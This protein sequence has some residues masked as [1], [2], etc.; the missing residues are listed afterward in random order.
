VNRA[1][2]DRAIN[3]LHV[4]L[5]WRSLSGRRTAI[6]TVASRLIGAKKS[7]A[8][9]EPADTELLATAAFVQKTYDKLKDKT[10]GKVF[11]S[12]SERPRRGRS[13]DP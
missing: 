6:A 8:K 2:L 11:W 4:W 7:L 12:C 1:E 3:D 5:R 9:E 10:F 13:I